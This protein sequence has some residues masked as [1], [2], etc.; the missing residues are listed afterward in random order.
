MSQTVVAARLSKPIAEF[1]GTYAMVFCGTGAMTIN[2]V[3][4]GAVTHV[5]IGLAWGAIVMVMIYSIGRI[6]GC[7]INP[8]VTIAFWAAGKFEGKHIPGYLLAQT[9]GAIAASFTLTALFPDSLELGMTLFTGTPQQAFL[10]EMI[11]TFF[12]TFF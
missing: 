4:G 1:I 10:L 12:L 2:E 11:I 9:L 7:H 3:T 5:G 6:S 8:A